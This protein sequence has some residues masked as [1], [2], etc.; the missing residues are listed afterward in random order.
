MTR[1]YYHFLRGG[2]VH[3][4]IRLHIYSYKYRCAF[5]FDLNQVFIAIRLNLIRRRGEP[6]GFLR[7]AAIVTRFPT[8]ISNHWCLCILGRDRKDSYKDFVDQIE[9]LESLF[10]YTRT[11]NKWN[12]SPFYSAMKCI[13]IASRCFSRNAP[14]DEI[15]QLFF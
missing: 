1:A 9:Q 2:K 11:T 7:K 15:V 4:I 12:L 5:H 14:D 10:Q 8:G 13:A 6:A 3:I